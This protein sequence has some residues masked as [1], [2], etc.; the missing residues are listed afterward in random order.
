MDMLGKVRRM[1]MRDRLSISEIARRTGL[2]RNTVRR[3]LRAP[4]D[5]EPH[6]ERSAGRRKL[7]DYEAIL[8]AALKAD[9]LRHKHSRRTA[10]A[11]FLQIKAQG[12]RGGYSRVTD[13]IRAWRSESSLGKQAFVPLSFEQGE[14]FQ[15]DWS[16]EGV[17]VGGVF[18]K[19]Q[20]A[21]MK[22]CASRGFFLVAYPSQ[23][24]EMLF[25]AHTRAFSAF[26][27]VP[28]RGIYDNMKTAIDTVFIGKER[29]FNR[30]FMEMQS[31]Y[32][33]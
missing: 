24:H 4:G 14:A 15:F 29:K 26:G 3:W 23:S 2:S 11:L 8:I 28:K 20:V 1:H 5:L 31:H 10:R 9:R 7:T 13:F 12:Y 16:E 18:H 6:Y 30:R 25:D 19:A 32:L 17:V 21:H 33:V 27:G 22:L